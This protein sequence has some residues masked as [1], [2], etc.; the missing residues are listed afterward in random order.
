MIE[1]KD[2]LNRFELLY[3]DN[4]NI[5]DLR[6]LLDDN[7][8][9]LWRLLGN[10]VDS[11][12]ITALKYFYTNNIEFDRDCFSQ[13]QLK[14]K[15]WLINELKALDLELGTV[16]LCAGW[17]GT[18][19]TLMFE[20]NLNLEK[21]R[22]FDIDPSCATIAERFNKPWV[23]EGWK[24]KATTKNIFDI[25]YVKDSYTVVKS[26][27][28]TEQLSD[29]PATIINTSCEHIENFDTWY[30]KIPK[31]KLVILQTNDYVENEDHVNC[32]TN[33]KEFEMQTPMTTCLYSGE[34]Q[35]EKYTRYMRIGY[36]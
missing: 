4:Q 2:L 22:S 12:F 30:S 14:S 6:L 33:L 34:L 5:K 11:N 10:E 3:P 21:I 29:E 26:D 18:L 17:Y 25:N 7:M 36:R 23:M 19:A 31:G 1:I 24:F 35:L 28:T 8:W 20:N 16:F 15:L 13:G 32:S 27:G 9:S